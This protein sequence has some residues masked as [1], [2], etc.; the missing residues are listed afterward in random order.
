MGVQKRTTSLDAVRARATGSARG[1]ARQHLIDYYSGTGGRDFDVAVRDSRIFTLNYFTKD[2]L[3]AVAHLSVHARPEF[4]KWL[5]GEDGL[6]ETGALLEQIPS[7]LRLKDV[8]PTELANHFGKEG[9]VYKLW[10]LLVDH[11]RDS[12]QPGRW[13]IQ[14]LAIKLMALKRQHLVPLA[15]TY[16]RDSLH[17]S[18][19]NNWSRLWEVLRDPEIA[20]ALEGVRAEAVQALREA[21][22]DESYITVLKELPLV[23]VLDVIAWE[24]GKLKRKSK[25][26][27]RRCR[28]VATLS[29]VAAAATKQELYADGMSAVILM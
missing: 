12:K 1:S 2:D 22:V 7:S 6:R 9:P 15:D 28:G 3:V 16:V 27:K 18:W 5:L 13:G 25:R 8:D 21:K 4:E 24:C 23:R 11:L 19:D 10:T 26:L 20:A 29:P 17:R 14:V